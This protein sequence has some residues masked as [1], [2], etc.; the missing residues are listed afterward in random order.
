MDSV[1]D[2]PKPSETIIC[3]W[4]AIAVGHHKRG[5]LDEAQTYYSRIL[6]AEPEH[7]DT[8]QLLALVCKRQGNCEQALALMHHSLRVDPDQP[9][10]WLNLGHTYAGTQQFDAA[11]EAYKQAVVRD[12][13][14]AGAHFGIGLMCRHLHSYKEAEAAF[15]IALHLQPHYPEAWRN[16]GIIYKTQGNNI[17]ALKAYAHA[18]EQDAANPVLHVNVGH[19]F[20]SMG[21]CAEA[22]A[23]YSESIRLKPD[24]AEAHRYLA[25]A[26][27]YVDSSNPHI[28]QMEKLAHKRELPDSERVHLCFA[29]AKAYQ[30]AGVV[31]K[32]WKYLKQGNQLKRKAY[33]YD[34]KATEQWFDD[35][36]HAY[37]QQIVAT[38]E[39]EGRLENTPIFIVGMP[40]SGASL[41]EQLIASHPDVHGAGELD[42]LRM[43]VQRVWPRWYGDSY[44][45]A[46]HHMGAHHKL[47]LAGEYLRVLDHYLPE[48][49][50]RATDRM[51]ENF[52]FIGLIHQLLPNAK[53]IHCVR[54]PM[55][56]CVSIYRRY[57]AGNHPY[58]YDLRELG[59]YYR[60]YQRLM[61]HWCNVLPEGVMLD[62]PY[63]ELV[64]D[65]QFH[66]RRLLDFCDLS[67]D[68]TRLAFHQTGRPVPIASA[69]QIHTPAQSTDTWR[70][71][72]DYLQPLLDALNV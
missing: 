29:L 65:Q 55:D 71:E 13:H 1:S 40:C 22:E 27:Y 47:Q 11:Y 72:A 26:R 19:I 61:E 9:H 67:W 45:E 12:Q 69:M 53:I 25:Q 30:D 8:L 57:F 17:A 49:K 14:N 59:M 46:A 54:D 66:M 42:A 3:Q 41:V 33:D 37:P 36:I 15:Q 16:L 52:R 2:S 50:S 43:L 5:A 6:A 7:A 60:Q 4:L 62:V 58:V 44:P 20:K 38:Q 23:A 34:A 56:V 70:K 10:V 24:F 63:E 39:G 51:P 64:N 32:S 35:I 31:V 21:K 18:L 68:D 48:G 28:A